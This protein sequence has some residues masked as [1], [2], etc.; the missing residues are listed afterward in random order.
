M[1]ERAAAAA[2]A[3]A[4]EAVARADAIRRIA[5]LEKVPQTTVKVTACV[6]DAAPCTRGPSRSKRS[7]C[8]PSLRPQTFNP[9]SPPGHGLLGEMSLVEA[10]ER[11][12]LGAAAE[13]AALKLKKQHIQVGVLWLRASIWL[14][15][16]PC[17][18]AA[19][20]PQSERREAVEVLRARLETISRLRA[21]A[22]AVR[23]E[24]RRR[25][26]EEGAAKEAA[27][28]EVRVVTSAHGR[29]SVA[30]FAGITFPFACATSSPFSVVM[31][32]L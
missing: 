5:A 27:E 31:R 14:A 24:A 12:A 18:P 1:E 20:A 17:Y 13:A 28:R 22:E 29:P 21:E 15:P 2:A 4:A 9:A 8:V 11:A 16:P 26:E 19:T 25:R 10:A 6:S 7:P 3:E 30:L 32:Q 23:A